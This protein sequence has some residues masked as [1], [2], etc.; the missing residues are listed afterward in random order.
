MLT[1]IFNKETREKG[2]NEQIYLKRLLILVNENKKILQY[3]LYWCHI[4]PSVV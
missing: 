4:C 1:N 3:K 2:G